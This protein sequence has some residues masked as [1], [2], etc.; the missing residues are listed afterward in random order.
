MFAAASEYLLLSLNFFEII[1]NLLYLALYFANIS[2][3]VVLNSTNSNSNSKSN[4][5]H[6]SNNNF[7]S[8]SQGLDQH[9]NDDDYLKYHNRSSAWLTIIDNKPEIDLTH[10]TGNSGQTKNGVTN[11]K[12]AKF[13]NDIMDHGATVAIRGTLAKNTN[14]NP[15]TTA[16]KSFYK[17]LPKAFGK[18][19][20]EDKMKLNGFGNGGSLGGSQ[21]SLKSGQTTSSSSSTS[22]LHNIA[23]NRPPPPPPVNR[24]NSGVNA[25][26]GIPPPATTTSHL[27]A[28]SGGAPSREQMF[29][30]L[31]TSI[32]GFFSAKFQLT[33][34]LLFYS[35][36]ITTGLVLWLYN[37]A[38][39]YRR[40]RHLNY[41]EQLDYNRRSST[42][43][44]VGLVIS[45]PSQSLGLSSA[46]DL[47]KVCENMYDEVHLQMLAS[48]RDVVD[49]GLKLIL[50]MSAYDLSNSL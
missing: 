39:V 22:S 20:A 46:L 29:I 8:D 23:P 41:P 42:P 37:H 13:A 27:A 10:N 7:N 35:I 50:I 6:S 25:L 45:A 33:W 47:T 48:R 17:T 44:T 16:K 32:F 19:Q 43:R 9:D 21:E 12:T 3:G 40:V 28:T 2:F 14:I 34:L 30:S 11:K 1:I 5:R 18:R 24:R 15:E 26:N 4:N 36:Y 49:M 38:F 31:L